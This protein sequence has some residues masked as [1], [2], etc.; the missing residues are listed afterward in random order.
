MSLGRKTAELRRQAHMTQLQVSQSTGLAVSYL[1]RLENDRLAPSVRTLSKIAEALRVPMASFFGSNPGLDPG[2]RCPV[3]PSGRCILDQPFVGRGRKPKRGTESYS[4]RQ[5]EA[6][7]LCN[8]LL[9]TGDPKIIS[10]LST[11]LNALLMLASSKN[12]KSSPLS[13]PSPGP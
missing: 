5:L 4:A 9:Q 8:F 6:L 7:R 1:S 11:M 10:S 3:S 2:D 13:P 12:K